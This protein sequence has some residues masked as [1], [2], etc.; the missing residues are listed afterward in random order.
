MFFA[1]FALTVPFIG[2]GQ[3]VFNSLEEIWKYADTHNI[4]IRTVKYELDKSALSTKQAYS[5]MLPQVNATGSYTDNVQL[6]TTLVPGALLGGPPGSFKTLQFGSQF[7]YTGG[8]NAQM[9]VLN[10][11]NWYTARMAQQTQAMN[12]DSLASTRKLVYQQLATQ[13][14]SYL[15][16]QEAANIAAQTASIADSVY[17]SAAD[18]FKE[19]TVN[20][21]NVDLAK[22]NLE[23]AQQTQ[24]TAYYQAITARNNLKSL[25]GLSAKDSLRIDATLNG[26]IAMEEAEPFTEDPSLRVALWKTKINLTQYRISNSA[27]LPTINILYNY[28]TQRYDK[29]FEPFDGATGVTGWFPSQ[30]WSLQANFPLFTSGS[31]YFQSRKN[32]INYEE[33]KAQYESARKV[34]EIN[35]DNIRLNYEKAV[36]VLKKSDD[37]MKLSFD[38][39]RHISYKYNEGM[40]PI[41]DRLNAFRDYIT[42]QNQYLNNLS[43]MLVQLY[44]VKLRQQAF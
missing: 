13:Y 20:E 29:T 19:G 39:Y 22:M 34:S 35:D 9:N 4:T 24:I 33:S 17:Q 26:N 16:M 38:N 15:L 1:L 41:D 7:V 10:L 28:A 31:H 12:K 8:I 36:I 25:L 30:Y 43:D 32:K 2:S 6:Q 27:F 3:V 42:Y 14:Y 11:Q 23:Q 37:V 40:S 44:Q 18:K 5:T 21:A